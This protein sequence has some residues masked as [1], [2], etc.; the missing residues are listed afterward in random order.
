V[1]EGGQGA[2]LSVRK[3]TGAGLGRAGLITVQWVRDVIHPDD[4]SAFESVIARG[5]VAE[6]LRQELD[7]SIVMREYEG[8]S[9]LDLH[10]TWAHITWFDARLQRPI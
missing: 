2:F 10:V 6:G 4:L 3:N 1:G 7:L 9:L 5:I 8:R